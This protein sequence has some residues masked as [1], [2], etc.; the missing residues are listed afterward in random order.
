MSHQKLIADNTLHL[1]SRYHTALAYLLTAAV[2]AICSPSFVQAQEPQRKLGTIGPPAR[3]TPQRQTA[4]E[5]FPPLPLPATPMRRSEPKAEPAAP[6]FVA[7]LAY[8]TTQDYTPNR[9]DLPS[10]MNE[11]RRRLDAWYGQQI[12]STKDLVAMSNAGNPCQIPLIYMTG[13]DAFTLDDNELAALREYILLG[14]TLLGDATLGS[15]AFTSSFRTAISQMFPNRK[16]DLL[17]MDHPIMHAFHAYDSVH[18]FTVNQGVKTTLESP[19]QFMGMNI[20]ARTA[21][22]LSPFDMSCGWDGFHAPSATDRVPGA[23][24]TMAMVPEDAKR[25]GVNL[26]AYV[27]AERRFAKAQAV[28]REIAGQQAQQRAAVTIGH[29][30]HQ[31]DWNPDPNSLYQL[32]R[33]AAQETSIP[34]SFD[35]RP[36]NA[37]PDQLLDTPTLIM[38]GMNAPGLDEQA[39]TNLRRHLQAGGVLFINNTS[40][41]AQFDRQVRAFITQVLPDKP[42][43]KL[44]ADHKIFSSLYTIKDMKDMGT[45]ATRPAE[46]FG[47]TLEGRLVII[48]SPN[49]TLGMLKT[50]HDPYANAYDTATARELALNI[51]CFALKQ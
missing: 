39:I 49:D 27:A 14:G 36:V 10:L 29:L 20:A 24:R 2:I 47:V 50:I 15:P 8:G 35:L 6:L 48:Y 34:M 25:M 13:Y 45:G 44:T 37:T 16:L 21:I 11:V 5:S 33:L 22:I 28:T 30:K 43:E 40:G 46:L 41:F 17:Q 1:R 9:G 23:P 7:K 38:T 19:P 32:I 3:Q 4:A 12:I 18:Y 51:L 31:G 42:L 26:V